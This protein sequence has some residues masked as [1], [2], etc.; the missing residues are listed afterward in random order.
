M[1]DIN[2]ISNRLEEKVNLVLSA[3]NSSKEENEKLKAEK[4]AL[5]HEVKGYKAEIAELNEK[6]KLMKLAQ[7]VSGEESDSSSEMKLKINEYIREID[8]CISLL[9]E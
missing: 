2:S 9:N 8:K 5:L 4:E 6:T 3:W 7:S 1:E